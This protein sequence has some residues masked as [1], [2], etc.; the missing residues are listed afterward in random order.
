MRWKKEKSASSLPF[1]AAA[2]S[3]SPPPP[4]ALIPET[5]SLSLSLPRTGRG[6]RAS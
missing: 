2:A 5:P 3:G 4:L 6:C 1:V